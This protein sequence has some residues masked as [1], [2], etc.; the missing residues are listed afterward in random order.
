[1]DPRQPAVGVF[2]PPMALLIVV[3]VAALE[4]L[5]A[6]AIHRARSDVDGLIWTSRQCDPDVFVMLFE[7][8]VSESD[9]DVLDC[10]DVRANAVF[11]RSLG[12]LATAPG[13]PSSPR[14]KRV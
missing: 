6:E 13:S 7:D 12:V 14:A 2:P 10:I 9:F 3:A 5:W 11:C 4:R 8:R 1:M